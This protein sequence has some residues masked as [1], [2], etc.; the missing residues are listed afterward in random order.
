MFRSRGENLRSVYIL[1]FLTI[2]FL[3]L[4]YQDAQKYARLF[5]FDRDA[6]AAG[7][8][9]RVFTYQF[10]QAGQG[11]FAFPRPLVLFFTLLLLYLMGAAIE[12]EWG[13]WNF[14]TFFAISTVGSAVAATALGVPLLG[15][16]FVNFSLLFVYASTF[17]QQTFYL[18]G[19]VPVRIRW[20]A[21]I[22]ALVLITGVF[23]GGRS[24]TAALAGAAASYAFFLSQR[25]RVI[26]IRESDSIDE[27]EM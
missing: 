2:A 8:V 26:V 18:F 27:D 7:E 14:L 6:V 1:L 13:T 15:S 4:E 11:W 12:E 24:N 9:W 5:S 20:V 19:T 10:T 16:Y 17:P 3:C 21:Y 23:A 25:V 22:A